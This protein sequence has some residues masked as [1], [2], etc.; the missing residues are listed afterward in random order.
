MNPER[1]AR[2]RE[3]L[4]NVAPL[5]ASER[6]SYLDRACAGDLDLRREVESL[7][8][9]GVED[10]ELPAMI[11]TGGAAR[12]FDM[13]PV[14]EWS[15]GDRFPEQIGPYRVLGILGRGGMG[16]V[17]LAEQAEPL[18]REVA[19]KLVQPGFDQ[20]SV[21]AR[22]ETERHALALME[23]PGIAR[24]L[25]AGAAADGR[26]YFVMEVVRGVPITEYCHANALPISDRLQLFQMVCLAVQHA[27]Q[28]GIIHRDLKPSNL[29]VSI[30]DGKPFPK[31][32]DFGI[33][34]AIG[35]GSTGA[36]LTAVDQFVGTLAYMSPE[37]A[38]G[39]S[40]SVDTRSDVYSLGVVL[41]EL[42]TGKLPYET[43]S[44][45]LPDAVRAIVDERPLVNEVRE[46]IDGRRLDEDLVTIISKAL[47]KDPERRYTTAAALAEDIER[48]LRGFP[49][50]AR[51]PS[52]LYQ[53]QKLVA[54][55]KA[56]V[57]FAATLVVLL[58]T[59]AV[60]LAVQLDTARRERTRAEAETLKATRTSE[61]LQNMLASANPSVK[62]V[63]VRVRDVLDDAAR[64]ADF[65]LT[66]EPEL[67]AAVRRTIGNTYLAL[68]LYAKAESQLR[69]AL[70]L[71]RRSAPGDPALVAQSLYDLAEC[72]LSGDVD[73]SALAAADTLFEQALGIRIDLWGP[74]HTEVATSLF[75]LGR[76]RRKQQRIAEAESLHAH[77][78]AIREKLLGKTH[79]DVAQSLT[80][81][82]GQV[83]AEQ[84]AAY[85][86]RALEIFQSNH[87]GDHPNVAAALSN[88]AR[89]VGPRLGEE[90]EAESLQI[91]ALE[92]ERRIWGD[93]HPRT[94]ESMGYL[95][96]IYS[97]HSQFAKAEPLLRR[98]LEIQTEFHGANS[99]PAAWAHQGLGVFFGLKG[100]FPNA[101]SSF[102][103]AVSIFRE[104]L[105]GSPSLG[106]ALNGL[107]KALDQLGKDGEAI[108][109]LRECDQ[110]GGSSDPLVASNLGVFLNN[111]GRY[112]EAEPYVRKALA[113]YQAARERHPR[114]ATA[115]TNLG[116]T[117]QGL[118][119]LNEAESMYR[120]ALAVHQDLVV[121]DT[122]S[123]SH[124]MAS[125]KLGE[126]L[127]YEGRLDEAEAVL[128]ETERRF[129]AVAPE[130]PQYASTLMA[131]G[132]LLVDRGKYPE[133]DRT[134]CR[135]LES[136]ERI[137]SM[138]ARELP[139]GR[140]ALAACRAAQGRTAEADSLF[141][142]STPQA[143]TSVSLAP[144]A[145]RIVRA[146]ALRF[147]ESQGRA[148]MVARINS[149]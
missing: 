63:D 95:G 148:D 89:I 74:E 112:T 31:V 140:N 147:Y 12:R 7:L 79:P 25:D 32:I 144:A 1:F 83:P 17:Y 28:K 109:V 54:R 30:Q 35:E 2:L 149:S 49:I 10:D 87:P 5:T 72:R 108:D 8:E 33:A 70:D 130:H 18:R 4:L 121:G 118:G 145:Q 16:V 84:G 46:S 80:A 100:D 66:E 78:L 142:L 67:E 52:T 97:H 104:K 90:A 41:H 37:Q 34:K 122:W 9:R 75:Q 129:R 141:R 96:L 113:L 40:G 48:N 73:V 143:W 91:R 23:H 101:E 39:L 61:F 120:K 127:H 45:P 107:G 69:R 50:L 138:H 11:R 114:T 6:E 14:A 62:N 115:Y 111:R 125:A 21:L 27:H 132:S 76:L 133:A 98:A 102:S 93:R 64:E 146:R 38:R 94:A 110:I 77:V 86:R 123:V 19:I 117:L 65:N 106:L 26:P 57:A 55:H 44:R 29:L 81:L 51:P 137:A 103:R 85:M 71:R 119:K 24:V 116:A 15:P 56:P 134:L 22:F 3:I 60:T 128:R 47:E 139:H 43:A 131:L 68:G 13:L 42:V 92:M 53:L 124:L 126:C 88:V 136:L 135:S 36:T 58:I 82:A 105:P 59:F 99:V 20:R